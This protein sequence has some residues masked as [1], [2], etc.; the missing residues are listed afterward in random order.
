M[1]I[2]QQKQQQSF[3]PLGIVYVN[4]QYKSMTLRHVSLWNSSLL[5]ALWK[6]KYPPKISSDPSPEITHLTPS[7]LIFRDMRNIG[8]LALIVVTSYV[9]IW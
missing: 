1:S 7:D 8:V 9:S 2:Q 3:I 4:E 5:G 6:Y